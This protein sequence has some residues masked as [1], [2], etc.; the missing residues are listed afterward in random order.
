MAA[1]GFAFKM[2]V[3][4]DGSKYAY[5]RCLATSSHLPVRHHGCW[6]HTCCPCTDQVERV[7]SLDPPVA[8]A[9]CRTG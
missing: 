8:L 1:H 5:L 2:P 3:K 9:P 7:L 6:Q 4:G